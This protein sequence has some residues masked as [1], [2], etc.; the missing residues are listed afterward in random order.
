MH[1]SLA[2]IVNPAAWAKPGTPLGPTRIYHLCSMGRKLPEVARKEMLVI[3]FHV[4][5]HLNGEGK[6]LYK[7]PS[8]GDLKGIVKKIT[9]KDVIVRCCCILSSYCY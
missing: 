9:F 1:F 4:G 6:G 8:E 5:T 2:V 7:L 3:L